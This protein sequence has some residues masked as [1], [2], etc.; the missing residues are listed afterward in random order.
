MATTG[1][2][3]PYPLATDPNNVPADIQALAS[4]VDA[5]PGVSTFTTAQ[6]DALTGSDLWDGR[7]IWNT[8]NNRHEVYSDGAWVQSGPLNVDF[9]SMRVREI[10]RVGGPA[11][12]L[13]R[14]GS[15]TLTAAN[16]VQNAFTVAA[17]RKAVVKAITL[18][19][20]SGTTAASFTAAVAG[21]ATILSAHS[22]APLTSVVLDA[23]LVMAAAETLNIQS[24]LANTSRFTV[25]YVDLAN[26]ETAPIRLAASAAAGTGYATVYTAPAGGAV[27]THIHAAHNGGTAADV[28]W[29]AR[30][31]A[32]GAQFLGGSIKAG[33]YAISDT[34]IYLA[35][36]EVLQ[37]YAS[38]GNLG[39][40][41]DGY[42]L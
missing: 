14:H 18:V 22:V 16:T 32:S 30:V 12:S 35:G 36:G 19:N 6:R 21:I 24:T 31:G 42:A 28:E 41:V 37:V 2:G 38:N 33:H 17:N 40:V 1:K 39:F 20:D 8:T 34:P 7:T 13:R 29:H 23:A 4:W 27:I 3:A 11:P 10:M 15:H 26:T 25:S 9:E 5:R